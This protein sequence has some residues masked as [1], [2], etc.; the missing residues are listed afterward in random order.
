MAGYK[1]L[2]HVGD[3]LQPGVNMGP[4]HHEKSVE[5]FRNAV[6]H[7]LKSGTILSLTTR[8]L[9]TSPFD[10]FLPCGPLDGSLFV[11][12]KKNNNNK[13]EHLMYFLRVHDTGW[14]KRD[15]GKKK[16]NTITQKNTKKNIYI[17]KINNRT[18]SLSR[19]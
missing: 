13:Y 16:H 3:P 8:S 12:N 9:S 17:K 6:T 11:L 7:Y 15:Q 18:I 1:T 19:R 10:V 5:L 4:V 14:G 2:V